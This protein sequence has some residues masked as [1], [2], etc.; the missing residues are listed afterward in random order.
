MFAASPVSGHEW[1][2]GLTNAIGQG[3]CGGQD[4]QQIPADDV[5]CNGDGCTIILK[6]GDHKQMLAGG[7]LKFL[8]TPSWS[9]TGGTHLCVVGGV[10]RC[11]FMDGGS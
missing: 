1:Y 2:S 4:C 11:L 7:T 9:P 3:C 8:D 5:H 6:P 10:A